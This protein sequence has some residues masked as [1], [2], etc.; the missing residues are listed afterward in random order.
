[1]VS[2]KLEATETHSYKIGIFVDKWLA[3][4]IESYITN[5][6]EE[7]NQASDLT[8]EILTF[9]KHYEGFDARLQKAKVPIRQVFQGEFG[10]SRI[11]RFLFGA[12]ALKN[13]LRNSQYDLVHFNSFNAMSFNYYQA[14]EELA[15]P[16][17]FHSHNSNIEKGFGRTFKQLIHRFYR[18]K[19][20]NQPF[21]RW[22]CS[23]LAANWLFKD[24][25]EVELITNGIHFEK[26][27]FNKDHRQHIRKQLN[28]TDETQLIGTI[29]RLNNQKNP[30]FL[31]EIFNCLKGNNR[32]KFLL[33]GEG[34]LKEQVMK[35]ITELGLN[36][37]IIYIPQ[38]NEVEHY[39][40]AMDIFLLPSVF[41]G[42]PVSSI[43]AQ[44]NGLTVLLSDQI[45][46]FAKITETT[47]FLPIDKADR[48]VKA[49]KQAENY[50]EET[51]IQRSAFFEKSNYTVK[52]S[53]QIVYDNY[54]EIL[55]RGDSNHL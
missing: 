44:A 32:Y 37:Q 22:A 42:N 19:Y 54:I 47:C 35:K 41:E 36:K 9:Y 14:C 12:K 3:G 26:F 17:I 30:F 33:I 7:L 13:R 52:K 24:N 2:K 39:L 55:N 27:A 10:Q 6:V 25:P 1:M 4:G 53:S 21:D 34:P 46:T 50:Q 31:F 43:E 38:T 15:I 11:H 49:M 28:I 5:L 48:W 51:R 8:I 16:C 45:T 23:D 29:G 40:A 18:H 20:R